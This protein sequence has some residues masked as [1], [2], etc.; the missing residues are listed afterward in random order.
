MKNFVFLEE[1]ATADIAFIAKGKDKSQIIANACLALTTVMT[2]VSLISQEISFSKEFEAE[3]LMGLVYDV[4]NY[5]L[6]LFDAEE[7]FFSKFTVQLDEENNKLTINAKGEKYDEKKHIIKTHIK[8]VTFFGM[9]FD[10]SGLKVT[11]DL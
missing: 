2:D 8:A 7:L 10:N 6:F 11:L 5:L 3:D 1:E 9:I 4:L